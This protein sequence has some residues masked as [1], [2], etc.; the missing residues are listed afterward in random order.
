MVVIKKTFIIMIVF[1]YVIYYSIKE[2]MMYQNSIERFKYRIK[3]KFNYIYIYI[4]KT[5]A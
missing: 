1:V 4:Y 2:N 3:F 5:I